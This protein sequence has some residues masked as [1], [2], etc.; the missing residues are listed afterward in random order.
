MWCIG[1]LDAEYIQKMEVVLDVDENAS[2]KVTETRCSVEFA[3]LIKCLAGKYPDAQPHR[4]RR[5]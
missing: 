1:H 5:G 2:N 3:K 4:V